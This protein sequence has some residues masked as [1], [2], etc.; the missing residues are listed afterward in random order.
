MDLKFPLKYSSG[1]L[2]TVSDNGEKNISQAHFL[3]TTERGERYL[4]P[5][6]GLNLGVFFD[7]QFPA[8]VRQDVE[9]ALTQLPS[10]T[11]EVTILDGNLGFVDL[12]VTVTSRGNQQVI[13]RQFVG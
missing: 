11:G 9:T 3:L 2:Q 8:E 1:G 10:V 4:F 13:T 5:R 6:F 7:P 12:E